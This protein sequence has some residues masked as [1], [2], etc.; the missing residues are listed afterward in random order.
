MCSRL[1]HLEFLVFFFSF[2][3]SSRSRHTRCI[4]DW[5]SDVCSSDL[6]SGSPRGRP[7]PLGD[8]E[9][10]CWWSGRD[11]PRGEQIGRASRRGGV[12]EVVVAVSSSKVKSGGSGSF[13]GVHDEVPVRATA[14][15]HVMERR[16]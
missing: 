16:S 11:C 12:V 7:P 5:S 10:P 14:R 13:R 15:A 3:F 6:L 1:Q 9:R 8:P 2:F 4:S